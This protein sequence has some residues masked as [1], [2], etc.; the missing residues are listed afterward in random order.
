MIWKKSLF[1]QLYKA[2]SAAAS[3]NVGKVLEKNE[4]VNFIGQFSYL[5]TQISC[6]CIR[7]I[8]PTSCTL[9]MK[10]QL[11]CEINYKHLLIAKPQIISNYA[12]VQLS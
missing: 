7:N 12:M 5:P 2:R 6:R 10:K 8:T 9:E 11:Y 3:T 1:N 4:I